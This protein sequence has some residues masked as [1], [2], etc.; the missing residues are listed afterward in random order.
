MIIGFEESKG[1]K[2]NIEHRIS[3]IEVR[4]AMFESSKKV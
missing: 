3:N 2:R 4:N 1:K